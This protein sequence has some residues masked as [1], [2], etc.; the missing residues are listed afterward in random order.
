MRRTVF[1]AA[2]LASAAGL[3]VV[4]LGAPDASAQAGVPAAPRAA[5]CN[6][7]GVAMLCATT[8]PSQDSTAINYQV[9]QLDGP[10]T[11]TVTYTDTTT[12]QTSQPQNVGPLSYQGVASGTLYARIQRCYN[13]TLVST[14]G[15]SLTAGPVCG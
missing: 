14:P 7:D 4:G 1:T 6:N 2:V 10:G 9:T 5:T 11:Y 15:T 12:G 13:V 3:A 8:L